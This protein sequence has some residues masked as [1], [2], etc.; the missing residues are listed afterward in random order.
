MVLLLKDF[1]SVSILLGEKARDVNNEVGHPIGNWLHRFDEWYRAEVGINENN[2]LHFLYK[3]EVAISAHRLLAKIPELEN[4]LISCLQCG[5]YVSLR[6]SLEE[7]YKFSAALEK[8]TEQFKNLL[9]I[10]DASEATPTSLPQTFVISLVESLVLKKIRLTFIGSVSFWLNSGISRSQVVGETVYDIVPKLRE[11]KRNCWGDY[12]PC[13]KW[14]GFVVNCDGLIYPC[15]GLI[16]IE[17]CSIGTIQQPLPVVW[18]AMKFHSL[19]LD[20][21]ASQG[22]KLDLVN[23]ASEDLNFGSICE[24]HRYEI[25]S[26]ENKNRAS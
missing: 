20:Q 22:P 6:I 13:T 5:F 21:L 12:N 19:N 10:I 24:A 14:F 18:E 8:L 25:I 9:L 1:R 4:L 16:G 11:R 15:M 2:N 17:S 26:K 3:R 23:A 7:C